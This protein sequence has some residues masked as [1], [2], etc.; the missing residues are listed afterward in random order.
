MRRAALGNEQR[1]NAARGIAASADLATIGI[2]D[3]HEHI[4]EIRW[5]ERDHLIAADAPTAVGDGR[6]LRGLKRKRLLACV[7][8][9][10]V[11]AEAVHL[12][13]MDAAGHAFADVSFRLYMAFGDRWN[14]QSGGQG[15]NGKI[16]S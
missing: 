6:N 8:H 5:L 15:S 14:Q 9:D 16:P 10:E 11:V 1:R 13:E 3:A 12:A 4:G 2:P 7:Q